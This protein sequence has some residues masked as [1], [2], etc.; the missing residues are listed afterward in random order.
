MIQPEMKTPPADTASAVTNKYT[1]AYNL[2]VRICINAQIAQQN[3]Y[4]VCKGLKEMHDN[5]LF[6]ELG[7]SSFE[8]YCEEEVG[9]KRHQ[10]QKYLA[11]SNM[12]N[13]DTYQHLGVSKLALLA[14][15]DEPQREELQQTTDLESTSVRELK[16]KIDN[17]KKANDRLM[18]K[19][20][21]AE[22]NV[23]KSQ[24]KESEAWGKVSVLRTDAEMQKQKISQ[25]ESEIKSR[26]DSISA[27]EE[28]VEEL[29]SRPVEVAVQSDTTEIEKLNSI[30]KQTDLDWGKKYSELEEENIKLRQE[31]FRKHAAEIEQLKSEYE[32]R[33]SEAE[34][35]SSAEPVPDTKEVFKA[36]LSNAVDAVKRLLSFVQKYPDEKIF[37]DKTKELFNNINQNM[38]V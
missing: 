25:L 20:F 38:E 16:A 19:N 11:V 6:K 33:L 34:N 13:G 37:R 24:E 9:I 27:L 35:A 28:Q 32:R 18:K 2:N 22:E 29:E 21:D 5:K 4:E 14:K 10:A 30:I 3:L 15:L 17:L 1:E 26:D 7:Y 8:S 12:E 36:Y 23:R 31:D